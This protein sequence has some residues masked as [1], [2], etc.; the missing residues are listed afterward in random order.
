MSRT[1]DVSLDNLL[2]TPSQVARMLSIPVQKVRDLADTG[3]LP[4]AAKT[5]GG[6]RRYALTDVLNVTKGRSNGNGTG[7]ENESI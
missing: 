3:R 2:L 1:P 6:H 5:P 7:G 4:V